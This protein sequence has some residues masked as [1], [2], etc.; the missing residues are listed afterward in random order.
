VSKPKP[1][2]EP[3]ATE[4]AISDFLAE[5]DAAERKKIVAEAMLK[6]E[7]AVRVAHLPDTVAERLKTAARGCADYYLNSWDMEYEQ[8]L[9]SEIVDATPETISEQL[10]A[11]QNDQSS[12]DFSPGSADPG[13]AH[14]MLWDKEVK[15][16]LTSGQAKAWKQELDARS[17]YMNKATATMIVSEF[18]QY[19]GLTPEQW[20]KLEPMVTGIL[21]QYRQEI[22]NFM[23]NMPG[24]WMMG[25]FTALVPVAGIP[26]K[27]LKAMLSGDQW[28]R[29]K[30]SQVS[31]IA[32]MYWSSVATMH[33]Q[34]A[35]PPGRF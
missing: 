35:R 16:D 7:D 32:T 13:V 29:W 34:A 11:I 24:T 26:E 30:A 18:D 21:D 14:E 20:T 28:N 5:R 10:A 4:S 6:A 12:N 3:E 31:T 17:A 22:E 33:Q 8:Q 15:A 25:N 19:V 23:S 9:R 27:D 1:A 2:P